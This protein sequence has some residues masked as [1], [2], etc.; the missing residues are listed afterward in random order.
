MTM[1]ITPGH[2]H[3]PAYVAALERG[4][5]PGNSG[6]AAEQAAQEIGHIALDPAGF[7]A[8][9]DDPHALNGNVTLPDGTEIPRLP[10]IRRWMWQDGL[11]GII[12]LRWNPDGPLPEHVL[13]HVGY[14][15]V[16]WRR[17]EGHASRALGIMLQEARFRGLHEIYV[18]ADDTNTGSI[19]VIRSNGGRFVER[20]TLPRSYGIGDIMV[21]RLTTCT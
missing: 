6:S 1:L 21:F 9:H 2:E 18:T 4:W 14:S 7:I 13:G 11:C 12:S 17:R 16:P 19:A 3:L 5:T 15:T 10:S 20:R 8:S